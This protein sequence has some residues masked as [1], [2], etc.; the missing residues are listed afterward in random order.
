[1]WRGCIALFCLGLSKGKPTAEGESAVIFV[2]LRRKAF[3]SEENNGI[4]EKLSEGA[5]SAQK[6]KIGGGQA[7]SCPCPAQNSGDS[8]TP[9]LAALRT[10][11]LQWY[12]FTTV[13]SPWAQSTMP[14]GLQGDSWL[15]VMDTWE[16]RAGAKEQIEDADPDQLCFHAQPPFGDTNK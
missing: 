11:C 13:F 16:V 8:A 12:L 3:S 6:A 1:M 10:W 14:A 7:H 9:R 5:E 4:R 15:E 2:A